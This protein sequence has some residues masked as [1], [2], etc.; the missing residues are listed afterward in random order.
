MQR[1]CVQGVVRGGQVV[2]DVP[3]E[4]P[5]G[6]VVSVTNILAPSEE[7]KRQL[8]T[9]LNRLDLMDDPD[10]QSKAEPD[11]VA[12]TEKTILEMAGMWADRPEMADPEQWVRQQRGA[13]D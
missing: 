4:L 3:L 5:D 9:M 13:R 2:L 8:L 1:F 7:Y 6:T 12:Y 11:R 10:W